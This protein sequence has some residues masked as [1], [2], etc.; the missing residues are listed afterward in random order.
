MNCCESGAVFVFGS[1]LAGRH[2]AGAA[3]HAAQM[4][5]AEYGVG[6]GRTGDSFAIPTKKEN[7]ETLSAPFVQWYV[8]K[9]MDYAKNHPGTEFFITRI[10]TGLAGYTDEQIAPMF[11]MHPNRFP[12]PQN[13]MLPILWEPLLKTDHRFVVEG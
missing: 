11:K 2:G 4:H 3:R 13:C 10:G 8:W 6:F 9:F 5:G 1:N 12:L 7:L